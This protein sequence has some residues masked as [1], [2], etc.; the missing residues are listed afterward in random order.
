[1]GD[2][3]GPQ[4]SINSGV[5][6]SVRLPVPQVQHPVVDGH[7][8]IRT[9][10]VDVIRRHPHA[11][12]R[13]QHRHRSGAGQYLG[14]FAFPRGIEMK[15]QH[16]SYAQVQRYLFEKTRRRFQAA[17]R[18]A[19]PYDREALRNTRDGRRR[20]APICGGLLAGISLLLG[21]WGSSAIRRAL[22]LRGYSSLG[23]SPR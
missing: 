2:C 16:I 15:H 21:L 4:E 8:A 6:A 18:C 14:Y 17:R 3:Q 13:L 7:F 19:N 9:N 5:C 20:F 23:T 22:C 12:F 1:M 11:V 10:D